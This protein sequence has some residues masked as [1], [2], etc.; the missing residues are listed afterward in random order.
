MRPVCGLR[1][2][3]SRATDPV[4]EA[5]ASRRRRPLVS[6]PSL[7]CRP[8]SGHGRRSDA[9]FGAEFLRSDPV[10]A[11]AVRN[12]ASGPPAVSPPSGHRTLPFKDAG[13][14]IANADYPFAPMAERQPGRRISAG[15]RLIRS[16]SGLVAA[17]LSAGVRMP[18]LRTNRCCPVAGARLV[19]RIT[20]PLIASRN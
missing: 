4:R 14:A 11:R 9:V 2:A 18:R 16:L 20:G 8:P 15:M 10:A 13:G 3:K 1:P 12:A 19:L 6:A 7:T 5:M 17:L